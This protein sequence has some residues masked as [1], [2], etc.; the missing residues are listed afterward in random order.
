MVLTIDLHVRYWLIIKFEFG[1]FRE[2]HDL[3]ILHNIHLSP[4]IL[5]RKEIHKYV[6]SCKSKGIG[7]KN[8]FIVWLSIAFDVVLLN[9]NV[10]IDIGWHYI[11]KQSN[12]FT[13]SYV[14]YFTCLTRSTQSEWWFSRGTSFYCSYWMTAADDGR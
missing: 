1:T 10:M 3:L 14:N 2:S 5:Y 6:I 8:M 11:K 9:N 4:M 7:L 13:N 12:I